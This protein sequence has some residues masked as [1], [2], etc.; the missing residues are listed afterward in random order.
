MYQK[1]PAAFLGGRVFFLNF[2]FQNQ[3]SHTFMRIFFPI[4]CC[5]FLGALNLTTVLNAQTAPQK[6]A[7]TVKD[8]GLPVYTDHRP[9]YRKWQDSYILDKIEYT[10][11]RTIFYFRFVNQY[12]PLFGGMTEAIFYPPKGE[13]PW[14]LR[15]KNV[16]KDFDLVGIKNII[17]NGKLE[18]KQVI[19]ELKLG[20]LPKQNTIFTCEVHFERLPNDV[21]VVDLIEGRGKE[22]ATNHFNCFNVKLKTWESLDLGTQEESEQR[23]EAFNK[24]FGVELATPTPKP[25]PKIATETPKPQPV[26]LDPIAP[27]KLP[28]EKLENQPSVPKPTA[29]QTTT[30]ANNSSTKTEKI[31]P[32]TATKQDPTVSV[33]TANYTIFPNPNKGAF[34]LKNIGITQKEASIEVLDM[35]GKRLFTQVINQF[36]FGTTQKFELKNLSAGQY[37]VRIQNTDKT[38]ET[39]QMVVVP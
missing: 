38:I 29:F 36:E 32:T 25:Q 14:Y 3:S 28:T 18:A 39:L 16:R 7:G 24:K 27:Q 20:A 17:R 21:E 35:A 15:G 5:L 33:S 26:Q 2:L 10:E 6:K 4:L 22:N 30:N 13:H 37:L 12:D 8:K 11:D 34:E 31:E 19:K 1:C 23:A 9:Q